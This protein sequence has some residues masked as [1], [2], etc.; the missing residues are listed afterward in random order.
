MA[1]AR[2]PGDTL[3]R[4][5][6]PVLFILGVLLL[7]PS[8]FWP[9]R[10]D[11]HW[12]KLLALEAGAVGL[13]LLMT[14]RASFSR[15]AAARVLRTGPNLAILLF[16][17][18]CGFTYLDSPYQ[19]YALP[20]L[21]QL[22]AGVVVYFAIVYQLPNRAHLRSLLTGVVGG[23]V[24]A[25]LV[26]V[27]VIKWQSIGR[28]PSA[29]GHSQ[30][31]AAFLVVTLPFV[32]VA[33]VIEESAV[34]RAL[35]QVGLLLGLVALLLA[36]S[37]SGWI[38]G[39]VGIGVLSVLA[40][41]A[42]LG[43]RRSRA[44]PWSYVVVPALAIV[45]SIGTYLQVSGQSR[46]LLARAQTLQNPG[47]DQN[48]RWRNEMRVAAGQMFLS[49]PVQGWGIGSF[50]YYASFMGVAALP[51]PAVRV[52]GPSLG[53]M[54]HNQ[55]AQQL[56]ETGFVG[57]ALYLAILVGF[58]LRCG[59][60]LRHEESHSRKWLRIGA[61]SAVAAQAVDAIA[62]PAWQFGDVG[63]FFWLA[64][65]IGVAAS[66]GREERELAHIPNRVRPLGTPLRLGWGIAQLGMAALLITTIGQANAAPGHRGGG[67][68]PSGV[69]GPRDYA[70]V[71]GCELLGP[72]TLNVGQCGS[73]RLLVTFE[74]TG[75]GDRFT[76]DVTGPATTF[77]IGGDPGCL[78]AGAGVGE[79]CVPTSAVP[80]CT[81]TLTA[82]FLAGNQEFS[83]TA[84]INIRGIS[85]DGNGGGDGGGGSG[86]IIAGIAG[87]GLLFFLLGRR[88]KKK[89]GDG[90]EEE[91]EPR[92]SPSSVS[93]PAYERITAIRTEPEALTIR[94]GENQEAKVIRVFVQLDGKR[95][96]YEVTNDRDTDFRVADKGVELVG[97]WDE[98][99]Q[100]RITRDQARR[101]PMKVIASFRGAEAVTKVS[102]RVP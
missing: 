49:S 10:T 67:P 19:S 17:A 96:W 80:P 99:A 71:V 102:F 41:R 51:A 46:V 7:L 78:E 61:M 73:Y 13:L 87:A 12:L 97:D 30:L 91:E 16:L 4:R 32:V 95:T 42:S 48:W 38:A 79:F 74:E 11:Y 50:P 53:E 92:D 57:L 23:V 56:A 21:L 66:R 83:C 31:F 100:Y 3:G 86:A 28:L 27:L 64:L 47:A 35:A 18:W 43:S 6:I 94:P 54:A 62:N 44:L 14:S 22:A 98:A 101:G 70:R 25:V 75:T 2:T 39:T 76:V 81:G 26:S 60:R 40:A 82:I 69:I 36:Q 1:L 93:L 90:G 89:G 52:V 85:G 29:L 45:V 68:T 8:L 84:N 77:I 15:E 24:L 37:R 59:R 33:A 34:R 72:Q 20:Q 55:Y 63:L 65:G 5:A 9:G 58:F 88:K